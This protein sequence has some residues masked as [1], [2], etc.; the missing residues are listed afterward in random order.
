MKLTVYL[1]MQNTADIF[2]KGII[3]KNKKFYVSHMVKM[4][5]KDWSTLAPFF[6]IMY[7]SALFVPPT[8]DPGWAV[9]TIPGFN[10]WF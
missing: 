4:K 1:F 5:F 6:S 10:Q 3:I 8:G 7:A 9:K 2:I